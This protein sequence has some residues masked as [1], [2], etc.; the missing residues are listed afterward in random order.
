[1]QSA[2]TRQPER[3][4]CDPLGEDQDVS[5]ASSNSA[6]SAWQDRLKTLWMLG[7]WASLARV[8]QVSAPDAEARAEVLLF[9]G[10]GHQLCGR[11]AQARALLLQCAQAA[12]DRSLMG[13]V[14]LAALYETLGRGAVAKNQLRQARDHFMASAQ[15]LELGVSAPLVARSRVA[16]LLQS[17]TARAA[18]SQTWETSCGQTH[19][20]SPSH[21]NRLSTRAIDPEDTFGIDAYESSERFAPEAF[22]L[23]RSLEDAEDRTQFILIDSKSLPRSGLHYLKNR[24]QDVLGRQFSFC[25][26]YQE[27]GCCQQMPCAL[28]AYAE[29]ARERDQLR[30]RLQKS[31]DFNLD[32]PA[33]PVS[34]SLLRL[35]LIRDPLY[36]LTSWFELDRLNQHEDLLSAHAINMDKVWLHHEP[37]VLAQAYQLIDQAYEP[38]APEQVQQWLLSRGRYIKGFL[39]RWALPACEQPE[40]GWQLVRYE[41]LNAWLAAFVSSVRDQLSPTAQGEADRFIKQG[42]ALFTPRTDPF[43]LKSRAISDEMLM[44]ADIFHETAR[45]LSGSDVYK[46]LE[47][48]LTPDVA[49]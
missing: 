28:T 11:H 41:D 39:Q 47:R 23:Y 48:G 6:G 14:L 17:R 22:A 19:E 26:W 18:L 42:T 37:E 1:M 15:L 16:Q 5:A 36:I 2:G 33:F 3:L 29:T 24:L 46:R 21:S 43:V 34:Q 31:H 4:R 35:V 44:Y 45:M 27:P 40:L 20:S 12:C 7:D 25:E 32:D 10:A 13:R 8:E 9:A 30:V 38:L 49:H